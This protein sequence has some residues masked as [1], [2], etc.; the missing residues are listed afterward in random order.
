MLNG[1]LIGALKRDCKNCQKL[2][3]RLKGTQGGM[4]KPTD[5]AEKETFNFLAQIHCDPLND[6]K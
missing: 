1:S 4:P 5:W 3:G 2:L 6:L